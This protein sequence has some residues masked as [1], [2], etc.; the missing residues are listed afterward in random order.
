MQLSVI[1]CNKTEK[2]YN[3][4]IIINIYRKRSTANENERVP[5]AGRSS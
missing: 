4:A 3:Y 2:W 5:F 1:K